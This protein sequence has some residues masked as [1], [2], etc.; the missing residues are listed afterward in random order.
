MPGW[1]GILAFCWRPPAAGTL[2]TSR[3]CGET[4]TKGE[5]LT[6]KDTKDHKGFLGIC[7]FFVS[8]VVNGFD[9]V[10]PG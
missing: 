9:C 2:F 10:F 5:K 7:P 6:T 4:K 3:C 1:Q 8:C